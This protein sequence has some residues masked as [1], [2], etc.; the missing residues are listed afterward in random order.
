[1]SG[2]VALDVSSSDTAVNKRNAGGTAAFAGTDRGQARRTCPKQCG[3]SFWR[4]TGVAYMATEKEGFPRGSEVRSDE[5]RRFGRLAVSLPFA[6]LQSDEDALPEGLCTS[7]ISPKGMLFVTDRNAAPQ[8]GQKVSFELVVPAG[9][10]YSTSEGRIS[11]TG[12]VVRAEAVP[13]LGI[14]I[15]VEFTEPLDLQF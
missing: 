6:S 1:M 10:G 9:E 5:R 13:Q 8:E 7:N 2:M 3:S 15:G 11:G 4:A 14:G 12:K